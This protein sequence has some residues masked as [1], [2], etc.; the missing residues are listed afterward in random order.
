MKTLKA[1]S[2]FIFILLLTGCKKEGCTNKTADN[3]NAS[4][5]KDDG[6]CKYS[7]DLII[8]VRDEVGYS[9][10]GELVSLY[11][12]N[13]DMQNGVNVL[14]EKKTDNS[15]QVKFTKL[16]SGVYYFDCIYYD[17]YYGYYVIAEGSATVNNGYV[18][19]TDIFGEP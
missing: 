14:R 13:S 4:A 3:Y 15:G 9:I 18:T 11:R 1:L 7:G 12:T 2:F 19:T 5:K 16:S 17:T 10:T 8:N 6:S